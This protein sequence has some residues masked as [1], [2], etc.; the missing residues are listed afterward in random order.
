MR[1]LESDIDI[2]SLVDLVNE[3][4]EIAS[5][6]LDCVG[7]L[8]RI[9][10]NPRYENPND[11]AIAAYCWVLF[12]FSPNIGKMAAAIACTAKVTWWARETAIFILENDITA[13]SEKLSNLIET[14]G[15]L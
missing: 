2:K 6:I 7:E 14:S 3:K 4:P 8:C 15:F 5:Q 11:V 10:I 1:S 12:Q 13:Q 9:S